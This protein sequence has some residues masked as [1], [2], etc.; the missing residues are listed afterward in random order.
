MHIQP[1]FRTYN[2]IH[3]FS[4]FSCVIRWLIMHTPIAML[5][6]PRAFTYMV[7]CFMFAFSY[8]MFA[9]ITEARYCC[10]CRR[11]PCARR[12]GQAI[13]ARTHLLL[14]FLLSAPLKLA[15]CMTIKLEKK[16]PLLLWEL[17]LIWFNFS[18]PLE[19][20]KQ[21]E[22]KTTLN[23]LFSLFFIKKISINFCFM[24]VSS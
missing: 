12:T 4:H 13:K 23:V 10:L 19:R 7:L 22:K 16:F 21:N 20:S 3:I 17:H 2:W 1:P 15:L 5:F 9:C 14:L 8:R 24:E 18:E 11:R 6:P